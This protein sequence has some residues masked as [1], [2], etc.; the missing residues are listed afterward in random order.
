MELNY[1]ILIHVFQYL[2]ENEYYPTLFACSL[3]SRVF[4]DAA[5][6]LLYRKVVLEPQA[7]NVLRLGRRDQQLVLTLFL[8]GEQY[9]LT[10]AW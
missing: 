1:D 6:R 4:N 2:E 5:S 3:V 7:T 8:N 9:S 10:F